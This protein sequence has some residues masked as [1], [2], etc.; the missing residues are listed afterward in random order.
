MNLHQRVT[1]SKKNLKTYL[2]HNADEFSQPMWN[3]DGRYA[4]FKMQSESGVY[5]VNAQFIPYEDELKLTLETGI[6]CAEP[7]YVQMIS[8]LAFASQA[9]GTNTMYTINENGMVLTTYTLS[10]YSFYI[11]QDE[12]LKAFCHLKCSTDYCV[13][14]IKKIACGNPIFDY[15]F[16]QSRIDG[17]MERELVESLKKTIAE[18]RNNSTEAPE[19]D[20]IDTQNY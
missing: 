5:N 8:Y 2:R 16:V 12:F 3:G 13:A 17:R 18:I 7:Y 4:S 9:L 19:D 14:D 15:E 11:E 10:F 20:E 1:K 6:H